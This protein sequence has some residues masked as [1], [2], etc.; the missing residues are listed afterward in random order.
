MI[1]VIIDDK[2]RGVG[3][4]KLCLKTIKVDININN[5]FIDNNS[6]VVFE[7]GTTLL[8]TNFCI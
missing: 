4:N 2:I 3:L 1:K 7:L 8:N 6:N 5:V